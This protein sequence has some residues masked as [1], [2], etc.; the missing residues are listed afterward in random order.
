MPML[1]L[2]CDVWQPVAFSCALG[3]DR[4]ALLACLLDRDCQGRA[5]VLFV[6][7]G[8]RLTSDAH[9]PSAL[10]PSESKQW[11]DDEEAITTTTTST[12]MEM[13]H[14]PSLPFGLP[15]SPSAMTNAATPTVT[16]SIKMTGGCHIRFVIQCHDIACL[17]QNGS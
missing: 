12:A 13:F 6:E 9:T 17:Q 7:V 11:E 3:C 10:F 4:V 1:C 2:C 5:P 15:A 16:V 14:P 8:P